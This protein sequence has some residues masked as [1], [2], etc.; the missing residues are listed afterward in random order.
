ME[1]SM[2]KFTDVMFG[3]KIKCLCCIWMSPHLWLNKQIYPILKDYFFRHR[4]SQA[5]L[6]GNVKLSVFCHR[7]QQRASSP[8]EMVFRS[9]SRERKVREGMWGLPQRSV[10]SSTSSSDLIHRAVSLHC[11]SWFLSIT[12]SFSSTN[13]CTHKN[14]SLSLMRTP[15]SW[16]PPSCLWWEASPGGVLSL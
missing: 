7:R 16:G 1:K 11:S 15:A 14:L 2:W 8:W 4:S 9:S 6:T 12:S 5:F 10:S 13:T 3:I